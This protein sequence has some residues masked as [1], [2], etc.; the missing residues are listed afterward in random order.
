MEE[1]RLARRETVE[2]VDAPQYAQYQTDPSKQIRWAN[3]KLTVNQ[4]HAPTNGNV[5]EPPSS[6]QSCPVTRPLGHPGLCLLQ[7][8]PFSQANI[9]CSLALILHPENP[10]LIMDLTSQ[11]DDTAIYSQ[12]T[13]I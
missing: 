11:A 6:L 8:K 3:V 13:L 9:I 4:Q 5:D 1:R 12:N 10:H 2:V 7:K